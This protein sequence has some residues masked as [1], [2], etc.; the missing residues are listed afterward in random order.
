[1]R[2][3]IAGS[4]TWQPSIEEIDAAVLNEYFAIEPVVSE[5]VCG[6]APGADIAGKIWGE[7][8]GI[9]VKPMPADWERLHKR[10]GKVRNK[11][12]ANYADA[13]IIFWDEDSN[14]STNMHAWMSVVGKPSQ[15]YTKEYVAKLVEASRKY[16][17][18]LF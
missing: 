12:M 15:V 3:I 6:L 16:A 5:V 10:A 14:G 1:M 2:L 13:A 7:H 4:R 11:A 8:H 17:D 18:V 9:Y